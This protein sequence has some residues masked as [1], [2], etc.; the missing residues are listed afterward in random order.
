MKEVFDKYANFP[1]TKCLTLVLIEFANRSQGGINKASGHQYSPSCG[2]DMPEN[3]LYLSL[4]NMHSILK[5]LKHTNNTAQIV[6][7]LSMH[8][9]K[10]GVF[11]VGPLAAYE[12]LSIY[13][14]T[15]T[16]GNIHHVKNA[17]I[18]KNNNASEFL[19]NKY[20]FTVTQQS[21]LLEVARVHLPDVPIHIVENISC[22]M[23]YDY[24][25]AKSI[26]C[27]TI[28]SDQKYI[29]HLI[30]GKVY[31]TSSDGKCV[32]L[33]DVLKTSSLGDMTMKER[34]SKRWFDTDHKELESMPG[35][36]EIK[37]VCDLS[38]SLDVVIDVYSHNK[39]KP[40][41]NISANTNVVGTRKHTSNKINTQDIY[42][43]KF[44]ARSIEYI[45]K[46]SGTTARTKSKRK[47]KKK[48][49]WK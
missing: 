40:R 38:T 22:K 29:L 6:S 36:D 31:C 43:T 7:E 41:Q 44:G 34:I 9:M 11:K 47:K 25:H 8:P 23:S 33:C 42:T 12:L 46:R 19:L 14:M 24:K 48:Q 18:A 16:G 5:K 30:D 26:Q 37:F 3:Y 17:V 35:L 49:R 20:G 45:L 13:S 27:D 39:D 15:A 21:K 2:R 32:P 4:K 1:P 28:F 10:G